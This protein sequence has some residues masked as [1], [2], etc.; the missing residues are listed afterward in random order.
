MTG[1]LFV[2]GP[3]SPIAAASERTQLA[4]ERLMPVPA[5]FERRYALR[6][7]AVE[8]IGALEGVG[9]ADAA[10]RSALIDELVAVARD[11]ANEADEAR[12]NGVDPV[13][14]R[15]LSRHSPAGA[16][17]LAVAPLPPAFSYSSISTYR[18][19][20]L[21]Y[22]FSYV[23]GI[24]VDDRKGFFEFGS[25]VHAAFEGFMKECRDARAAGLAEPGYEVLR[26][27][28]DE[29]FDPRG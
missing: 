13:T 27:K 14:L 10:A 15:V 3:A 5:A 26:A 23:Y 8:L 6:R 17:L 20:P 4:L 22:A 18:E 7:R 29:A 2:R 1:L 28:F 9:E 19:C 11:A 24:T 21:R 25:T 16:T 12:R